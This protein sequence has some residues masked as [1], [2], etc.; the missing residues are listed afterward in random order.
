MAFK[1]DQKAELPAVVM[2]AMLLAKLWETIFEYLLYRMPTRAK[3]VNTRN[4]A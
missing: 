1:S 2:P 4:K 3:Q